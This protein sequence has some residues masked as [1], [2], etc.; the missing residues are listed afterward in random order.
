MLFQNENLIVRSLNEA[1]KFFLAKWLS[2]PSILE[3][4]E[5][6]DHP[7]DIDKVTDV[8]YDSEDDEVKCIVEYKG[9]EIGYIQFYQLDDVTKKEYGYFNENV[10]GTDQFI[11][12]K[13]NWNKGLGTLLVSS[14]LNY[15]VKYEQAERVVMDPQVRN[16][17][18]IKCYEKCGFKKIRILPKHELHEGK[19]QDCWLM[20]YKELD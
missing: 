7:F 11:G 8:F 9:K 1:D 5:G 19:Y 2:D 15:L 10:Y 18:A 4:Y 3:F 17:R 16:S 14:M 6:R 20:E 13:A 12:E